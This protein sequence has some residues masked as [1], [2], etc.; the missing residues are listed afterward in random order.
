MDDKLQPCNECPLPILQ[1]DCYIELLT[2]KENNMTLCFFLCRLQLFEWGPL[3][4]ERIC[5]WKS[6]FF[7]GRGDPL[8]KGGEERENSRIASAE[9]I[10]LEVHFN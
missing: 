3:F 6:K 4:K 10:S 2:H 7:L 1:K 9:S 5:F 8:E